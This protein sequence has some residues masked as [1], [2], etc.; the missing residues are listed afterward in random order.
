MTVSEPLGIA[1]IGC[2]YWG[3]N[4]VRLLSE[5]PG[6]DVPVVCDKAPDRLREVSKRFGHRNIKLTTEVDEALQT[7][8]VSAV[9]ICTHASTHFEV[10]RQ[11]LEAGK[12]ILIEKPM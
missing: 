9:V 7:P 4:Y 8:G 6:V 2:G 1:I 12:H 11:C 10:A 5:L 3:M